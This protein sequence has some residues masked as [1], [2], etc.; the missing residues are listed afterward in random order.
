MERVAISECVDQ[1]LSELRRSLYNCSSTMSCFLALQQRGQKVLKVPDLGCLV[2]LQMS[3]AS[4]RQ[5]RKGWTG[6]LS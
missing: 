3:I 1:L 4:G 2:S 6:M 5:H